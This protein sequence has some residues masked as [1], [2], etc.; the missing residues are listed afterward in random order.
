MILEN[1]NHFISALQLQRANR[2]EQDKSSKFGLIQLKKEY[3]MIR[4]AIEKY[5]DT[6][7]PETGEL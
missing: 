7:N 1:G 3:W 4:R 6:M 2:E 5:I